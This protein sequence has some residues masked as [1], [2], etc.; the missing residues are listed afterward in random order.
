MSQPQAYAHLSAPVSPADRVVTVLLVLAIGYVAAF[1]GLVGF[2]LTVEADDCQ[3]IVPCFDGPTT[4][5]FIAS[6]L[7]PVAF[8]LGG[9]VVVIVRWANRRPTW[10]VPLVA[11]VLGLMVWAGGLAVAASGAP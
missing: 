7:A 2:V 1:G 4:T 5:G 9:L 6:A 3:S 11:G 10:W 8:W